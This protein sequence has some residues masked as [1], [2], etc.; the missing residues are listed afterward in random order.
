M[1][2]GLANASRIAPSVISLKVTRRRL[3]CGTLAASATCHAIASPSR[4]R[5]LASQT[6]SAPRAAFSIAETCLRRSSGIT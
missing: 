4:S 2:R 1:S 5:S 6:S 3:A